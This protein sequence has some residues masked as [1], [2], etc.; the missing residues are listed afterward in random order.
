MITTETEPAAEVDS[1]D[2]GRALIDELDEQLLALLHR[3]RAISSQIQQLR[4]AGGGS[5][6][7]H[8]RELAIIRRYSQRLGSTGAAM[9]LAVLGYCRGVS[10][11]G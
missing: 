1:V 9:A 8:L 10:D 4:M 11:S 7:E 5:R 3:R 2:A 6:V